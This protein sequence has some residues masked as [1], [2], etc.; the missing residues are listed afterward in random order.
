LTKKFRYGYNG[1]HSKGKAV[2]SVEF[3]LLAVVTLDGWLIDA[4]SVSA[5]AWTQTGAPITNWIAVTC[6]ADAVKLAAFAGGGVIYTSTN[7]GATWN[8]GTNAPTGSLRIASSA[9]GTKLATAVNGGGIYR[10]VDSGWTWTQTSAPNNA[11][12]AIACSA[13]GNKIAALAQ[14]SPP[15]DFYTSS[16]GGN[17]WNTN[18]SPYD[19]WSDL[20]C[21]ADGNTLVACGNP[22]MILVSTNFGN[23]WTTTNLNAFLISAASSVDGNRLMVVGVS[24]G[25]GTIYVSTNSGL[26][27]TQNNAPAIGRLA[28]SANGS[29]LV[30]AGYSA[31][32]INLPIYASTDFGVTWTTNIPPGINY[33]TSVKPVAS[34]ADGNALV[35]AVNGGGIWISQTTPTPQLSIVPANPALKFSWLVPSTNFVLQ[36]SFDLAN[37]TDVTGSPTLNLA[38]LQ[39]EVALSPTNSSGFYRLQSR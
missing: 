38:T 23:S 11:W 9:D 7:S 19:R 26:D 27:W 30:A 15:P 28:S 22:G 17:T 25:T 36:Q 6:S 16:D 29:K 35:A 33:Y 8:P 3:M 13:D 4:N 24:A 32:M 1:T 31:Y 21:S 34:S 10:S 5:Q 37:W 20:A 12:I 2:K 14:V 39:E 18:A